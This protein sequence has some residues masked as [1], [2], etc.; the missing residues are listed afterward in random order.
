MGR[1]GLDGGDRPLPGCALHPARDR[2][3]AREC[4]AQLSDD[5]GSASLGPLGIDLIAVAFVIG[6]LTII[7]NA[8]ESGRH[9]VG[10][11][12]RAFLAQSNSIGS[13]DPCH[14]AV[15][16]S[17]RSYCILVVLLLVFGP[18]RLPE[19]GGALGKGIREFKRSV[20]DIQSELNINEIREEG[21][22]SRLG[23]A[24]GRGEAAPAA[25]RSPP[26]GRGVTAPQRENPHET[27]AEP[28]ESRPGWAFFLM[29]LPRPLEHCPDSEPS[30]QR[31]PGLS[32]GCPR[33]CGTLRACGSGASSAR[34]EVVG[35]GGR[36]PWR[37]LPE[38]GEETAPALLLDPE[39]TWA[40]ELVLA[41]PRTLAVRLDPLDGPR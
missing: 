1:H 10:R 3:P 7:L 2:V 6:P 24:V 32:P 26:G 22:S 23:G 34:L 9:P 41:L 36:P 27:E 16:G 8:L 25:E 39:A 29:Q 31:A 38:A 21:D 18:R 19:L 40:P 12:G 35:R 15:W 11:A 37:V 20:T 28:G 13:N 14:S 17:G 4:G 30:L 5:G 33:L